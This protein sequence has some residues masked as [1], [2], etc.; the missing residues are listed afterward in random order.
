[1][2]ENIRWGVFAIKTQASV[3]SGGNPG[4]FRN[5]LCLAAGV[6]YGNKAAI[7]ISKSSSSLA[8]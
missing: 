4:G 5:S 3:F 8:G 1:M 2:N 6:P 7:F